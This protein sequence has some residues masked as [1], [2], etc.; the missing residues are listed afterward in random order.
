MRDLRIRRAW[1]RSPA[2]TRVGPYELVGEIGRGGMGSVY[3]ARRADDAFKRDVALKLVR[4]RARRR[5]IS[6]RRFREE[7]QILASFAHPNIATLLDGG[8]DRGRPPRTS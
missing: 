8:H 4:A 3:L 7:R 5:R 2:G 1:T 6:W